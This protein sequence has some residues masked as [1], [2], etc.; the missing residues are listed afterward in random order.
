[1]E[2]DVSG[3]NMYRATTMGGPYTKVNN[4][5]IPQTPA[6]TAPTYTDVTPTNNIF[7][8]VV[9]AVNQAGLESGSSNE[10]VANP[11]PPHAPTNLQ[12]VGGSLSIQI[13]GKTV[14]ATDITTDPQSLKYLYQLPAI[15]PPRPTERVITATVTQ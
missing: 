6:G 13:D 8:Y 2:A 12:I 9:R 15:R 7:Y 4:T 11:T 5:L 14:T 10:V 1:M 3:Y